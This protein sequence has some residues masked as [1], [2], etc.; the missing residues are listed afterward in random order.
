MCIRDRPK[1]DRNVIGKFASKAVENAARGVIVDEVNKQ[2]E[3]LFPQRAP[4][5]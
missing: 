5:K 4:V 2:F 1:I 3:R